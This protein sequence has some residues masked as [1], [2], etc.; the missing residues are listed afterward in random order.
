[1]QNRKITTFDRHSSIDI[2][3][4]MMHSA[5]SEGSHLIRPKCM[6]SH[7]NG[8]RRNRCDASDAIKNDVNDKTFFLRQRFEFRNK[9]LNLKIVVHFNWTSFM[10]NS[11]AAPKLNKR[12]TK[13]R[14]SN[15]KKK[16]TNWFHWSD[17]RMDFFAYYTN[18]FAHYRHSSPNMWTKAASQ[19][20]AFGD[21][22]PRN[23]GIANFFHRAHL[24]NHVNSKH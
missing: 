15:K 1:M 5:S 21:G 6:Q 23:D 16:N 24:F 8:L 12:T 2:I 3:R 19:V 14:M 7:Q 20:M 10:R 18:T 17:S 9:P 4:S 22:R 11:L 13:M